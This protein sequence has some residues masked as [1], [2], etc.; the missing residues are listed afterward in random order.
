MF[1]PE[2]EEVSDFDSE[3]DIYDSNSEDDDVNDSD[4]EDED[5]NDSDSDEQ[6]NSDESE[7]IPPPKKKRKRT[8]DKNL[9]K[10]K[11]L[12][13]LTRVAYDTGGFLISGK[14]E[15]APMII[16]SIKVNSSHEC[17]DWEKIF[18]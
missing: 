11:V 8:I 1:D 9:F 2:D 6:S 14:L 7:T 13:V 16:I 3:E 5:I 4:S 10:N 12:D 17:F 15:K 18:I